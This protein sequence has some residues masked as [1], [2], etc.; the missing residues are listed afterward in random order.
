MM[1]RVLHSGP[2]GFLSALDADTRQRLL[3][4]QEAA[5][6]L[7]P[8]DY[9]TWWCD[10]EPM[11]LVSPARADWL[12]QQLPHCS[13]QPKGCVWH[14]GPLSR[15][16]RS[17]VLQ[18]ALEAAHTQGLL[19]GWRNERF[20]FWHSH[21]L[22]PDPR[23]DALLDVERA[24]FRFLGMLSHA[25]H[26]N[27]FLPDG[28]VWIARR[29][30]SKATDPGMLDN[31]TAGGLPAGETV[32]KCLQRELAEEAGLHSLQ[33]QLLQAAGSIRTSRLEAQGWHDE[34]LHVFNLTLAPD[35]VPHNTDGE[36]SEFLCL[37]P[38]AL[39]QRLQ[40]QELTAD[41]THALLQGLRAVATP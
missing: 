23:A 3:G 17:E 33:G 2:H 21:C 38:L 40:A 27:G 41:A 29:A 1:Q 22:Q 30:P 20:S 37:P 16:Q 28:R 7:P 39:V 19:T 26:V 25:V 13:H 35:F 34:V 15:A 32:Q 14:A 5:S 18:T 4:T 9:L 31:V 11:G 36:V 6:Q 24:G 8:S 10:D 12:T